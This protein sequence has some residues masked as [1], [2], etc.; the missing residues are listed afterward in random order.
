MALSNA[1]LSIPF[2][3][4]AFLKISVKVMLFDRKSYMGSSLS[5]SMDLNLYCSSLK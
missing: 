5:E 2:I 4:G 3:M 1:F